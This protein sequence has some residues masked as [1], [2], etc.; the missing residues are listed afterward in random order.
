M[1]A[2]RDLFYKPRLLLIGSGEEYGHI[3]PEETP[4]SEDNALRPGNIYAAT[5]AC[6]NMIGSIY[7][8]AYDMDLMMVRAFNHIGF[9]CNSHRTLRCQMEYIIGLYLIQNIDNSLL[10]QNIQIIYLGKF[11]DKD[12]MCY[13]ELGRIM[14]E[15]DRKLAK[16]DAAIRK[17]EDQ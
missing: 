14:A 10:I 8:K 9:P 13:E 4:I 5:K 6:Q 7:S 15:H 2:V 3:K 16:R 11:S 17:A 1:D 12:L